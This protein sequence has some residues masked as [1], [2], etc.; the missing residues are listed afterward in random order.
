[1][2]RVYFILAIVLAIISLCIKTIIV[3]STSNEEKLLSKSIEEE[4]GCYVYLTVK[5]NAPNVT[6]TIDSCFV[7]NY[8]FN[9]A[10]PCVIETGEETTFDAFTMKPHG[11][12]KLVFLI[13][14]KL[15]TDTIRLYDGLMYVPISRFEETFM[16]LELYDG[17]PWY[18]EYEGHYVKVLQSIGFDVSVEG[19]EN[20]EIEAGN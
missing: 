19:W 17:C 8:D 5:N 6:L 3:E 18:C 12:G 1:M 4:E 13:Y 16:E 11:N 7:Y 9:I 2:K 14:G 20:V 15:D 10:T